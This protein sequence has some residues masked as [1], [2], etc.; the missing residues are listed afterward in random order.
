MGVV[1]RLL[2]RRAA[3]FARHEDME[4]EKSPK[5]VAIPPSDSILPMLHPSAL[6]Q[7]SSQGGPRDPGGSVPKS[8]DKPSSGPTI[9]PVS[10]PGAPSAHRQSA[11][12]TGR[13]G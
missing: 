3:P 6:R 10:T 1:F 9:R 11:P 7:E 12:R 13:G 4:G 2:I 5:H 8:P